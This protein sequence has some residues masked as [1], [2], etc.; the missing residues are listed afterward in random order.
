MLYLYDML[1]IR[2]PKDV[3]KRLEKLAAKT[4]RTKTYYAK[5]A[6]Q[7]F[8]DSEEDYLIAVSRLEKERPGIPIKEVERRL[9]LAD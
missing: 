8:L 7:E 3:E 2:L 1:A 6:I 5:E 9:G 4:G